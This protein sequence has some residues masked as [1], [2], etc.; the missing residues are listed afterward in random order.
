MEKKHTA[1]HT[2]ILLKPKAMLPSEHEKLL[3]SSRAQNNFDLIKK[4]SDICVSVYTHSEN[5]QGANKAQT[6]NIKING[7]I[8]FIVL[9]YS[10]KKYIHTYIHINMNVVGKRQRKFAMTENCVLFG[11]EGSKVVSNKS[12]LP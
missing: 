1:T 2:I 5:R 12:L 4:N 6:Y 3:A 8:C 10:E 11:V 9:Y 7:P